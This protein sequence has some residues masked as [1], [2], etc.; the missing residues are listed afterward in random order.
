[1]AETCAQDC[2]P[3]R[4]ATHWVLDVVTG[5]SDSPIV[6]V[7]VLLLG[8]VLLWLGVAWLIRF[9]ERTFAV[10]SG[11]DLLRPRHGAQPVDPMVD[12]DGPDR[13]LIGRI[14]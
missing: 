5:I 1:M 7:G 12:S 3:I 11:G 10:A 9:I 13:P 14:D 8:M 4:S 6:V 2:G